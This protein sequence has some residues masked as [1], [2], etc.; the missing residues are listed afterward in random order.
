MKEYLI[1]IDTKNTLGFNNILY[2]QNIEGHI[3]KLNYS[4]NNIT[5]IYYY[6]NILYLAFIKNKK[7][8]ICLIN[9]NGEVIN[10]FY[11]GKNIIIK[12]IIPNGYI[13]KLLITKH[14]MYDY[15]YYLK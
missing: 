3:E 12:S 9:N 5:S 7:S 11:I 8:L 1:D 4:T 2:K 14:N 13:F 6:K 10:T 15:I